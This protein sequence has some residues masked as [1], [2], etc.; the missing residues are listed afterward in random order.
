MSDLLLDTCAVLWLA[1]GEELT[2]QARDALASRNLRVSPISAWE[3]A[4]LVRKSRL[5]ITLPVKSWFRQTIGQI[6]AQMPQLTVDILSDSCD[7]P[8][9]PPHDPADRIIIAT[10]REA[11]MTIVTRDRQILEYS[12]AGYVRALVC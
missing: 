12:R 6:D 2:P 10:A 11:D 5:A 8:G 7:L 4:N 9:F 1:I 3:I